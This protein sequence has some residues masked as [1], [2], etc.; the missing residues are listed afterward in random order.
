[1][2]TSVVCGDCTNPWSPINNYFT[3]QS[4]IV[5]LKPTI[6]LKEIV[7]EGS[8]IYISTEGSSSIGPLSKSLHSK[9]SENSIKL[10]KNPK[11]LSFH[12]NGSHVWFGNLVTGLRSQVFLPPVSQLFISTNPLQLVY[13][14]STN[15]KIKSKPLHLPPTTQ[16]T[17]TKGCLIIS[18]PPLV[19]QY[20]KFSCQS[21]NSSSLN[22]PF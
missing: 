12:V 15:S 19:F 7:S 8:T 11:I 13:I 17:A 10:Y 22:P 5:G 1:M 16:G 2:A 18:N 4:S 20:M 3:P 14:T 9:D 6:T 21:F